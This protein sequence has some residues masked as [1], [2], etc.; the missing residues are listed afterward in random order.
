MKSF[1]ARAKET[2]QL[3]Q[4]F[5]KLEQEWQA[6]KESKPTPPTTKAS[7]KHSLQYSNETIQKP[8]KYSPRELMFNLQQQE[9]PSPEEEKSKNVTRT[10]DRAVQEILQ[11]RR[12]AIERGKLKGRRLFHS[13]EKGDESN[14]RH[15]VRSMSF[16]EEEDDESSGSELGVHDYCS[17]ELS[18]SSSSTS[19]CLIGG[20]N[21]NQNNETVAPLVAMITTEMGVASNSRRANRS[22]RYAVFL[23][24]VAA[25]IL[26]VIATL[27]R[28]GKSF[29]G[30]DCDKIFIPT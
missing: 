30:D 9:S 7:H 19:S 22:T 25:I 20:D 24:G 8:R 26:L 2:E 4:R 14:S 12:E 28:L 16:Y 11:E 17:R 10:K 18:Y 5:K 1:E 15:E 23:G 6:F 29:G 3:H 21:H 13:E 27:M